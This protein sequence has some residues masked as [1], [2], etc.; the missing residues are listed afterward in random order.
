[1]EDCY[2]KNSIKREQSQACLNIAERKNFRL[3]VKKTI[4]ALL[5][6]V[7]TSVTAGAKIDLPTYRLDKAEGA[8]AHGRITFKVGDLT[9]TG[10]REG[11]TVTVQITPEEGWV[12]NKPVGQWYAAQARVQRRNQANTDINIDVKNVFEPEKLPDVENTW[13]FVMERAHAEIDVL[14]SKII[15]DL[16]VGDIKAVTYNGRAQKPAVTVKDGE[17]VLVE[18]TDFTVAYSNNIDA[19]TA[20]ATVTGIGNY[21][22]TVSKQF[23]IKQAQAHVRFYPRTVQKTYGDLDFT[24]RPWVKGDGDLRFA[25]SD[26]TVATVNFTSGAVTIRGAGK[27]MITAYVR[28]SKNYA[29]G[30]GY[31]ELTV[32]PKSIVSSMVSEIPDQTYSGKLLSPEVVVTDGNAVL[33]RDIDYT[34]TYMD[35]IAPGS[36]K[37]IISGMGNYGSGIVRSF[38]IVMAQLSLDEMTENAEALAEADG[39]YYDVTL[40]RTLQTGGW[41]SFAVPFDISSE[42]LSAKG[43]T[44]KE[45]T[46]SSLL[47]G[48]LTLNFTEAA[49]IEAGKPYLVKVAETLENPTF[50]RV[51]VKKDAVTTETAAVNFVPTLGKT[52]VTGPAGDEDN[53]KAVFILG[54]GNKMSNPSSVN[55]PNSLS[56]YM[57]GFRAYFQLADNTKNV[58]SIS[59]D[60]DE[61]AETAINEVQETSGADEDLILYDLQGRRVSNTKQKGLYIVN[62]KKVI[63]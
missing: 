29:F 42:E 46:G 44:A 14:Y 37:A 4:I 49:S 30:S 57:K 40:T 58:R 33:Q 31:Y 36:G 41:N 23:T 55:D 38:N 17:N 53:A 12:V 5:A 54:A 27:V 48:A 63:K 26:K 50:V 9:A 20:T 51:L 61:D 52:L 21:S 13:S 6:L 25:T 34:L 43:I 35:N 59:L 11:E 62:G 60:T 18:N 47:D 19:G 56:S 2:M 15:Q 1:M 24:I 39:K 3:Q 7:M 10:A 28:S 45:L 22:G 32:L 16:W 8:E